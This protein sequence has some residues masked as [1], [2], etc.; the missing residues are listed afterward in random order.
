MQTG[1]LKVGIKG[2]TRK[3]VVVAVQEAD[4][5]DD[6]QKLSRGALPVVIRCFNR[7]WRI[8]NQERSGARDKFRDLPANTTDEQAIALIQQIV[9]EYDPTKVVPRT[10]RPSTPKEVKLA[11]GKKTYTVEELKALMASSGIKANFVEEGAA[12]PAGA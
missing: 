1:K 2:G 5:I 10:G 11:K 9:T 7:G 6:I 4:T 12:A 8:E 3:P